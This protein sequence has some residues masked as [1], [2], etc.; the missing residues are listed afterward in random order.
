MS[1]KFFEGTGMEIKLLRK[2]LTNKEELHIILVDK[3]GLKWVD[4]LDKF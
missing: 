4:S 2:I 1:V 3:V